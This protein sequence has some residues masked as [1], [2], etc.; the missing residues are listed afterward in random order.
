MHSVLTPLQLTAAASL[1]NNT[2]LRGFRTA[3]KRA[4]DTFRI[5]G[6]HV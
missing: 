2:G 1:L 4:I 5:G 6:A 3:L